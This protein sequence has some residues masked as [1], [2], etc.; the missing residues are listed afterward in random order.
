MSNLAGLTV[1]GK[2][3]NLQ[4]NQSQFINVNTNTNTNPIFATGIAIETTETNS[5][6]QSLSHG[7]FSKLSLVT[8]LSDNTTNLTD[9]TNLTPSIDNIGVNTYLYVDSTTGEI[10]TR[11]FVLEKITIV[12][13]DNVLQR[14]D[15]DY[16]K[17]SQLIN[18]LPS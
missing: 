15:L 17:L 3:K 1:V 4:D 16:S 11:N 8:P 12:N 7:K 10:K 6:I 14:I 9:D 18:L 13:P 5:V 2:N